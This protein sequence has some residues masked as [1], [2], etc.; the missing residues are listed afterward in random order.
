[1]KHISILTLSLSLAACGTSSKGSGDSDA[2]PAQ[3]VAA[4]EAAQGDNS[5]SSPTDPTRQQLRIPISLTSEQLNLAATA[6][7]FS[8]NLTGCASGQTGT[9]T[10]SAASF[11]VYKGD[12]SCLAK[13]TS[14]TV[15]G[16]AYNSTNP[17]AVPFSSFAANSSAIFTDSTGANKINVT[18]SNQLSSPVVTADVIRYTFSIIQVGDAK[19]VTNDALGEGHSV[20]VEGDLLPN[21]KID[22]IFFQGLNANG[23][24]RF[25][26]QT[27]CLDAIVTGAA[28]KCSNLAFTDTSYV[29]VKDTFNGAPTA[30]QLAGLFPGT[31]VLANQVVSNTTNN[32]G[33]FATAVLDGPN[34][35]ALNP[36][37]ILVLKNGNSFQYFL[38]TTESL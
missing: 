15:N 21:F 6:S 36:K 34:Q 3:G 4:P 13:M 17:S 5:G 24:G 27:E 1:M 22:K 19:S 38:I 8:I 32:L 20:A 31:S 30:P 28:P 9:A 7:A 14:L 26:F 29:L 35:L 33:G 11:K 2:T 37:M 12:T 10:E 18:V 23:G 25:I 16:K